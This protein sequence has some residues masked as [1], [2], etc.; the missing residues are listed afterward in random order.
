M[1]QNMILFA[2]ITSRILCSVGQ[3]KS[4]VILNL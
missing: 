4:L 1:M 3:K 2:M